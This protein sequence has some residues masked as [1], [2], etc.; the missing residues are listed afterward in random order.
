MALTP[1]AKQLGNLDDNRRRT[2]SLVDGL[3]CLGTPENET[4]EPN[5]TNLCSHCAL[6]NQLLTEFL[7][8]S[9]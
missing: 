9:I 4:A 7:E 5:H 1:T 3:K 6:N 8:K 2:G